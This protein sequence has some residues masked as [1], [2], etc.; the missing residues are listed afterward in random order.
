M[1]KVSDL[2]HTLYTDLYKKP[3]KE[4]HEIVLSFIRKFL[5]KKPKLIYLKRYLY[6]TLYLHNKDNR[7]IKYRQSNYYLND[8][9]QCIYACFEGA[10]CEICNKPIFPSSAILN[11]PNSLFKYCKKR[12]VCSSKCGS[13][14]GF[15]IATEKNKLMPKEKRLEI[16][17]KAQDTMIQKYGCKSPLC[18]NS[19]F[20]EKIKRTLLKK[21]GVEKNI[22][23]NKEIHAKSIK[24]F[25]E[26]MKSDEYRQQLR[27]K[28][29]K[30]CLERY[31]VKH[32]CQYEEI[33]HKIANSNK[34]R[35][36]EDKKKT[37]EK[38]KQ[39][40]L[41]RYG[42][43]YAVQSEQ[44][45]KRLKEGIAKSRAK[46]K[47]LGQSL[48][49][50]KTKIVSIAQKKYEVQS[51]NEQ[52]FAEWL[53]YQK[54]Y[55]PNDVIGQYEGEYN[56]FIYYKIKTFPDFWIKSKNIYIEVKSIFT[57][58]NMYETKGKIEEEALQK[59]RKKA[60]VAN[61]NGFTTRWVIC[62]ES[63][64]GKWRFLLLPKSWWKLSIDQLLQLIKTKNFLEL[65]NI[66]V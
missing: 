40:C 10:I 32:A 24:T 54:G 48:S 56:D 58:F 30:T 28:K 11:K 2:L 66:R 18:A 5:N 20:Q 15:K 64:T 22:M 14:H 55:S 26:H 42:T 39:T 51:K 53:I 37:Q 65:K 3:R 38:I 35:S 59:N 41:S 63:I 6:F 50:C 62:G 36:L 52:K 12:K 8:Y 25:K 34:A 1:S 27:A 9:Q 45:K 7:A 61:Q 33:K 19:I 23:Q 13:I 57:F 44:I 16:A 47:E 29:E 49:E 21:Y 46:R 4:R 60:E 31:G 43:E 17:K